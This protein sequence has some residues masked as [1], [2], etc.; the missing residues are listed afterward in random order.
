MYFFL[1][2][3]QSPY[4]VYEPT[5]RVFEIFAPSSDGPVYIGCA[6]DLGEA[7]GIAQAWFDE[8]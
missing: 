4:A 7:D 1:N 6:D 2:H 8:A 3:T 5:A